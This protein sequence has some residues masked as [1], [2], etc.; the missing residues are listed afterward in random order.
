[1]NEYQ[2]DS[3]AIPEAKLS[4]PIKSLEKE[5][6]PLKTKPAPTAKT[7]AVKEGNKSAGA[8]VRPKAVMQAKVN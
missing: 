7:I 6:V 1:V 4:E 2:E 3:L 8:P 5:S